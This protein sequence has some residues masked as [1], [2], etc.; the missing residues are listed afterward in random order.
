[1]ARVDLDGKPIAPIT[2]CLIG[3]GGF[4]GSHLCE[5][6]MVDTAHKAIVVDVCSG[7][8][9][10]LLGKLLPWADR[11]EF[12]RINIKNDSRVETLV[13]AADLVIGDFLTH[14]VF[15]SN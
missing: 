5:K 1:M 10:H 2:V 9:N 6:L 4:I 3:G 8:I 15:F 11:I 14:I 13:R 7:K 12:H